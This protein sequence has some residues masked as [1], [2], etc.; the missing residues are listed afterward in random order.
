[1]APC[2]KFHSGYTMKLVSMSRL[3]RWDI[4]RQDLTTTAS[5]AAWLG[6]WVMSLEIAINDLFAADVSARPEL[7]LTQ[8]SMLAG[9]HVPEVIICRSL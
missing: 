5:K 1:M 9:I 7:N 3:P 4:P 6:G 2:F 8:E